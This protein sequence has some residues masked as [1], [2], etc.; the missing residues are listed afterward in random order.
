MQVYGSD[1]FSPLVDFWQ[2]LLD[3]RQLLV[4]RV[5]SYY[6]LSRTKF[7]SLQKRHVQLE[8]KVEK[9]A[10]FFVLNRSSF[11]GTTLSGGMSP[12][13]P[14]FTPSAI[15]RLRSLEIHN[16]TVEC[17]DFRDAIS[18]H[19]DAFLYLDPPYVNGQALYGVKGDTHIGFDHLALAEILHKRERW[20]MSYNDCDKIR[21]LY[22][23]N[24]I[25]SVE[26]IYGMSKN[27]QSSEVLVLSR[28]LAI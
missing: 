22:K 21:E 11:S 10:A 24:P 8:N 5:E 12:G 4:E 26:W 3:N 13:H 19:S 14:R 28:D 20:I 23:D 2:V 15:E 16:L 6:P 1:I 18:K 25:L 9:A 17:A 27:K 7:Y